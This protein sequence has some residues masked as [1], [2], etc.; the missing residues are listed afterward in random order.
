VETRLFSI[1]H[2]DSHNRRGFPAAL[3]SNLALA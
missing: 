1:V 2:Q 3:I